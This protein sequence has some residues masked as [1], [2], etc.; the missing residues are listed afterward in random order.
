MQVV[1]KYYAAR[2]LLLLSCSC[3]CRGYVTVPVI[4]VV[5]TLLPL[6]KYTYGTVIAV[7][8]YT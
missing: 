6:L 1:V 8:F 5:A 7:H 4:V 3:G 2:V